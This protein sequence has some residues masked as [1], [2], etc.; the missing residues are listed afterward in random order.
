[1]WIL[2]TLFNMNLEQYYLS[3][4]PPD[5]GNFV[6]GKL[7]FTS[8]C[9]S[10]DE[11]SEAENEDPGRLDHKADSNTSLDSMDRGQTKKKSGTSDIHGST[12]LYERTLKYLN[13][14][15]SD[16]FSCC[17]VSWLLEKAE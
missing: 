1:M 4:D 10:E 6:N 16:Y 3:D 7:D 5:L 13:G 11:E 15:C 14:K 2:T 12:T 17:S 8:E 9:D